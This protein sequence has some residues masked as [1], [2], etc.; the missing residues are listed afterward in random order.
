MVFLAHFPFAVAQELVE[1]D[2][3]LGSVASKYS[4]AGG[5][6]SGPACAARR[7][8][9]PTGMRPPCATLSMYRSAGLLRLR[10]IAFPQELQE[11]VSPSLVAALQPD[12]LTGDMPSRFMSDVHISAACRHVI[13]AGLRRGSSPCALS[14]TSMPPVRSAHTP[15]HAHAAPGT[16]GA[17]TCASWLAAMPA[18]SSPATICQ[19][20]RSFC[21]QTAGISSGGPSLVVSP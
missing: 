18:G 8:G 12:R 2:R 13:I 6:S 20:G 21:V 16:T 19:Y 17:P 5:R 3:M 10:A 1:V 4:P 11:R 15:G 14:A 9:A 7:R